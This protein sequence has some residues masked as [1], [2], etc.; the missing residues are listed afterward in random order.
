MRATDL[1]GAPARR[2]GISGVAYD[3]AWLAGLPAPA[4]RRQMQLASRSRPSS[5]V[6]M[7]RLAFET[8]EPIQFLDI[9]DEV[10]DVVRGSGV[11]DGIVAIVSRHT[12]MAVRIQE[13]EPC[14]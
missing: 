13:A 10:A 5:A 6:N 14:C 4:D 12:T 3:T 8:T 9:T 1:L 2:P 7:R 11:A